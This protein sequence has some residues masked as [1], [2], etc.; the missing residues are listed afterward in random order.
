MNNS[1]KRKHERFGV[2]LTVEVKDRKGRHPLPTGDISRYGLYLITADPR[3]E[4]QLIQMIIKFPHNGEQIDV[5]GQVM[6]SNR[7]SG[8]RGE[9][10]PG[11]GIKF[12]SM[13]DEPR[14]MWED[15]VEQLRAGKI[16]IDSGSPAAEEGFEIEAAPEKE[17]AAAGDVISIGDEELEELGDL[18]LEDIATDDNLIEFEEESSLEEELAGD[19]VIDLSNVADTYGLA[20]LP[21]IEEEIIEE[22]QS[23]ERCEFPRK[24]A[25]FMIRMAD[26]AQMREFYIRDISL[27]G[28]FLKTTME[29][30]IGEKV[31]LVIVHP[32]SAEEYELPSEVK[33]IE[34]EESGEQSGLGLHFVGMSDLLRDSLLIFIETGFVVVRSS[35]DVPAES[36]VIRQIEIIENG[37]RSNPI[38]EALHFKVGMLYTYISDWA[39]AR[40]HLELASKLGRNIPE[41]VHAKLQ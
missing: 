18:D 12:F 38:D 10:T 22:L 4:R 24:A 40:E 14:R 21:E 11:M 20:D 41:A 15:F 35:V 28:I 27:G 3:P 13:P 25:T 26:I 9:K 23:D 29:R 34:F 33:R 2:R 31:N 16:N 7:G 19:G 8:Q 39:K 30:K 5:M 1:N 17:S 36:D 37:I 32:W 6:W